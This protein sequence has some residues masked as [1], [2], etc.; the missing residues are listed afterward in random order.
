MYMAIFAVASVLVVVGIVQ[1]TGVF[2]LAQSE[3]RVSDAA[4][5]AMDRIVREVRLAC[6]ISVIS[7]TSMTL[8][9]L[10]N[11]LTGQSC[12]TGSVTRNFVLSGSTMNIDGTGIVEANVSVTN[13]DIFTEVTGADS[14]A[15]RIKLS[16]S[17]GT[18]KYQVSRTYYGMAVLRG[19]Y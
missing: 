17:S 7:G 8:I 3:R 1:L 9:T 19:S 6:D 15:V 12:D 18:G 14:K 4:V 13:S 11:H 16:L 5:A 2:R 10:P